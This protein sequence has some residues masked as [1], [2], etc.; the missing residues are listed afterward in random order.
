VHIRRAAD[1]QALFH[2][3]LVEPAE[4][5]DHGL[6]LRRRCVLEIGALERAEDADRGEWRPPR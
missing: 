1:R 2:A 4:D 6:R 5:R 3:G